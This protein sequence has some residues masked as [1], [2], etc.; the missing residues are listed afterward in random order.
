MAGPRFQEAS[1]SAGHNH[2]HLH[3]TRRDSL[4]PYSSRP[5]PLTYIGELPGLHAPDAVLD[6]P[7]QSL[8]H[9]TLAN[10]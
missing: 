2:I 5:A 6:S 7:Q 1:G 4:V 8:K 9:I 3:E 10:L